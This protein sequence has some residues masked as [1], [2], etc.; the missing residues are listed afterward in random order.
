M[1]S[2]SEGCLG[3]DMH[4]CEEPSYS[5]IKKN[6]KWGVMYYT[7]DIKPVSLHSRLCWLCTYTADRLINIWLLSK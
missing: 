7:H 6:G 1:S 5:V 2:F 4:I 3:C